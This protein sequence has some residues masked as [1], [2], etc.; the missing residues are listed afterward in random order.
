VA[1][2]R[3][4]RTAFERAVAKER[5]AI[6]LHEAAALRQEHIAARLEE[7]AR[8]E[9]TEALRNHARDAAAKVRQRAERA[10]D[11]A[12]RARQRLED[13]GAGAVQS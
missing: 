4:A 12:A 2:L 1:N 3:R 7:Q 8:T 6:Q 9:P 11:R 13:E 10:K 5:G